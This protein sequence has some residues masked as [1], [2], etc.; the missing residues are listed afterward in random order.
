[1]ENCVFCKIIKAEIPSSKVW[2]NKEFLAFLSIAPI[3]PGHTLV[4]PKKHIDYIFDLDDGLLGQLFIMC[5]PI[6]QAIKK[7]FDP[8]TG[9]VG[10]MVAGG[11]IAHAHIHLIPMDSEKDLSFDRSKAG[12]PISEIQKAA[13]KIRIQLLS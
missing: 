9:K 3:N 10:I 2:E 5:K 8:K 7:A 1:M 4:I 6:A 12:V 13:E 11:E